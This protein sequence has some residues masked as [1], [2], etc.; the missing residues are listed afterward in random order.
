MIVHFCHGIIKSFIYTLYIKKCE[1]QEAQ[2]A[3]HL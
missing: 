3:K 2:T 1:K